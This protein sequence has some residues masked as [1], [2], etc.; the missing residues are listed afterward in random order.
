MMQQHCTDRVTSC[1]SI[2]KYKLPKAVRFHFNFLTQVRIICDQESGKVQQ[3]IF[4][5]PVYVEKNN[6]ED[7][8][9]VHFLLK[10]SYM[11]IYRITVAFEQF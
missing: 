5:I 9:S 3:H 10:S 2:C 7:D 4:I 8:M 11:P 6:V 1:W